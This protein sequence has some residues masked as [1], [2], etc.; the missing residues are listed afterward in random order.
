MV[1]LKKWLQNYSQFLCIGYHNYNE[2]FTVMEKQNVYELTELQEYN[3]NQQYQFQ[4][5]S[6]NSKHVEELSAKLKVSV[7][8]M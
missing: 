8:L 7:W 3:K 1:F 5:D 6:N 2:Y 4:D